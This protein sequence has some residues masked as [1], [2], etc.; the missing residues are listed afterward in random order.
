VKIVLQLG[1]IPGDSTLEKVTWARDAGA[2]GIELGAWGGID[3][4]RRDA[5]ICQ[6]ILPVTSICGNCDDTGAGSFDFL[7]PDPIKRRKSLD[8]SVA[9]LKLCGELGAV[10]QVIPPIFGPARVPDLSPFASAIELEHGLMTAML[11]ELGPIAAAHNT[12]VLLEPLNRYEQHYLRKL[13][14]GI[15]AIERAGIPPGVALL[16]DTFH[17]HIEETNSP[18]S[19]LNAAEIIK[20][21]HVA[22]NTRFEPGSGDIDFAAIINALL[23]TGYDGYLAYECSI[24][25]ENIKQKQ[26]A[27]ERS[28]TYLGDVIRQAN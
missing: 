21:V 24:T 4:L 6:N 13:S 11:N 20:H 27:L 3:Q 8:G 17:M 7:D 9:I 28:I 18:A 22:D 23:D 16:A 5:D 12:L 14:D 2:S 10:G 1:L 25:G 15:A 19:I 26:A